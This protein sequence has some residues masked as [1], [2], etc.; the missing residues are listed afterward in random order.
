MTTFLNIIIKWFKGQITQLM[1]GDIRVL[2]FKLKKLFLMFFVSCFTVMFIPLFF[3]IRIISSI[4]LIRF[5]RLPSRRIGHFINDVN[6][7]L[8]FKK[9]SYFQYDLFYV[10]KP[11]CNFTLLNSFKKYLIILPEFFL[12]PFVILNNIKF[13]GNSKHNVT[14]HPYAESADLRD[15]NDGEKKIEYF[16]KKQIEKGFSFLKNFGLDKKDK[17]VC[18][19]CRDPAYVNSLYNNT[20]DLAFNE[21][22]DDSDFRYTDIENFRLVSEY[23]T[24]QG[25]YVFRMGKNV[26]KPFSINNKKFIDYASLNNKSD[27]LDIFL[28]SHCEMFISTGAG[29]DVVGAVFDKPIVFVSN[30]MVAW[31]RSSNKKQLTIYKHFVNKKT[32]KNLTL[33][34]IFKSD[35]ALLEHSKSFKE[36][37]INLIENNS[38]DIKDAAKDML[39]LIKNNFELDSE[40]KT[41]QTK[42]WKLFKKN[43][44]EHNCSH[45]HASFFKSHIGY[46][47][48]IKYKNFLE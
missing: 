3:I 21:H 30:A 33:S 27:F 14:F 47:F 16:T 2:Q 4:I 36:K 40:K 15:R 25:Y 5:G 48:L 18:L 10:E 12:L 35:L 19:L 26:S 9:K 42:F 24:N 44:D 37:N 22:G 32:A 8:C 43:I 13:I 11:V 20:Y 41:L 46:N 17:F 29:L 31:T 34:E 6:L 1:R 7:Y 38:E 23:L 45:L 39:E 28:S